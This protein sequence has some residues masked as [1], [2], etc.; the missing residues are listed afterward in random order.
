MVRQI[1]I[2]TSDAGYGHRR[3][4]EA[5]E[6]AVQELYGDRYQTAIVN[7]LQDPDIPGLLKRLETDYDEM[8]TDDPTL[9]Q[10]AYSAT[11]APMVVRLIQD[12]TT[13]VMNNTLTEL[14]AVHLPDLIVTTHPAF[15]QAALRATENISRPIPVSVVVTDLI[16]VHSLWFHPK[17]SQTFVPTEQVYAQALDA[18]LDQDR[19]A[20]T[21]L[22]VHPAFMKETREQAEIR[23]ALG[24]E[25]DQTTALVVGS[26]RTT[27]TADIARLLDRS[28]LALQVVAVAGGN[29]ETEEQ[30]HA[31][32]WTGNVHVYGLANNMS[33]MVHAADF[34]A[35][36]AGGLMV[37]EALACG[38]PPLLYEALPG[39]EAGNAR[40]VVESGAGAWSPG[41]IGVLTTAYAWLAKD[42]QELKKH[43][44]AARRVGKPRAAYDIAELLVRQTG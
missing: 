13:T 7:P 23:R 43:Q 1:L 4:A 24:W 42:A 25:P 5:I 27:R 33:E 34:I 6:A 2:L 41:P 40:F 44:A 18:G 22:P 15:T 36:K 35:C 30:L 11:D 9:Y 38:V 14:V 19:V 16:G 12:V 20:L 21:G 29:T 10:L 8:V 28:G 3:A 37:T 26:P 39:Q 17:A 31:I 32:E